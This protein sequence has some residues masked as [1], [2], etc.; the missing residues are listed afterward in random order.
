MKIIVEDLETLMKAHGLDNEE[1]QEALIKQMTV[2]IKD[3][4]SEEEFMYKGG[5]FI[6]DNRWS[7]Q[8]TPAVYTKRDSTTIEDIHNIH[9]EMIDKEET[10]KIGD[11]DFMYKWIREKSGK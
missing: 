10:T 4:I 3:K 9:K 1:M 7:T 8:D 11:K 6:Q 2:E 5:E